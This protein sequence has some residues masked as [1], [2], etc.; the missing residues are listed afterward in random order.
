MVMMNP[1]PPPQ[2]PENFWQEFDRMLKEDP[3]L[4]AEFTQGLRQMIRKQHN[5]RHA[6]IMRFVKFAFDPKRPKDER[7]FFRDGAIR[8]LNLDQEVSP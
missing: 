2:P 5:K 4:N 1:K 6:L 3:K 7:R 8:L